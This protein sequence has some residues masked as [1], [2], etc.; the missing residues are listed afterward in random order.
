MV[1]MLL[2]LA[3]IVLGLIAWPL[4]NR[5]NAA[6]G[7]LLLLA[8]ALLVAAVVTVIVRNVA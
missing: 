5:E 6:G 1:T 7:P 4:Q 8:T 3:G 2:A